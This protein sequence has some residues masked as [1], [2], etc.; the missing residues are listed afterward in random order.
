VPAFGQGRGGGTK[1]IAMD[2]TGKAATTTDPPM[3]TADVVGKAM[4]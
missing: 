3:K 2:P 1:W 4:E